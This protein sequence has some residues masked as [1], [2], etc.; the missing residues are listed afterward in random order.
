VR[1]AA[2]SVNW[3]CQRW[4]HS[5]E[6][7]QSRS[8]SRSTQPGAPAFRE[9]DGQRE[10]VSSTMQPPSPAT[11]LEAKNP[12]GVRGSRGDQSYDSGGVNLRPHW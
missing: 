5:G 4:G 9:G 7:S 1:Y 8:G 11:I 6:Q 3:W 12:W 2:V 10:L